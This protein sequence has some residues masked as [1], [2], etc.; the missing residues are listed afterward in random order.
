M[1][2]FSYCLGMLIYFNEQGVDEPGVD[3]PGVDEPGVDEPGVDEPGVDEPGVDLSMVLTAFNDRSD[4]F[5]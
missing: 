5:L 3:E 4:D 2:G 1:F